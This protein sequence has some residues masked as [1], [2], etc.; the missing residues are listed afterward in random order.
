MRLKIFFFFLICSLSGSIIF[1]SGCSFFRAPEK[2]KVAS[3]AK[4]MNALKPSAYAVKNDWWK[5]FDDPVLNAIVRR[6]LKR[7]ITY[8]IVV[9]NIQV[10]KTYVEENE[11]G[12]FPQFNLN[13]S[14]SRNQPSLFQGPFQIPRQ[15]IYNMFQI[16][17]SASYEAD[18]WNSIGN[19]VNQAKTGVK[20]G[21]E[22]AR[23]VKLTLLS[24]VSVSYFQLCAVSSSISILREQFKTAKKILSLNKNLYKSGIENIEPVDNA[25]TQ[26][27]NI[28]SGLNGLMR[29]RIII[30]NTLAYY[31][32]EYPENFKI[33]LKFKNFGTTEY[34]RLIPPNLPSSV[35]ARR[36]DVKVAEYNVLSYAYAKKISLA[37]FFPIFF[38]TGDFGYTS[39]SLSDFIANTT[40]AWSYGLDILEPLFNYKKNIGQ[41][42][43]SKLQY[44]QAVLNYR[45]TVINAFKET[46]NALGSYG[47]DRE[48]LSV[49]EKNYRSAENLDKIYKVRYRTGMDSYLTYLGYKLNLLNAEYNLTNQN[50]LL[51]EDVI[52]IYNVL[53]MGLN[54]GKHSS[55]KTQ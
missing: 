12:L 47:K 21:R 43:R 20:I 22:D 51:R 4:F 30:K 28:K 54:R 26:M 36:P 25:E 45:D 44:K 18:V 41:Y 13:S 46:D 3:P 49:Y 40:N 34:S 27:N 52:Q 31:L 35:L 16:G 14:A 11:A 23:I 33:K 29:E 50:L 1:F 17:A 42:K 2:I 6:A 5:N 55:I 38:L 24:N 9:K 10:A 15:N 37:N 32:E 19:T 39:T 53:G 48:T 7:N 8:K